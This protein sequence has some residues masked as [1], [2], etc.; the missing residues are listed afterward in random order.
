MHS[1]LFNC[2]SF[3]VLSSNKGVAC[4]L[5]RSKKRRPLRHRRRR[6]RRPL[7]RCRRP[8]AQARGS[9]PSNRPARFPRTEASRGPA[10]F[11]QGPCLWNRLGTAF[12]P[13]RSKRRAKSACCHSPPSRCQAWQRREF[14]RLWTAAD[15]QGNERGGRRACA[16][17]C[18][19][20]NEGERASDPTSP[21]HSHLLP[22][23][24]PPPTPPPT[25]L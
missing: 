3:R 23:H 13:H 10:A 12:I 5:A 15:D 24:P 8:L 4:A 19:F 9:Q 6:H 22:P 14:G 17:L 1:P 20:T 16:P 11:M 21:P 2:L 25:P 18:M 7:S